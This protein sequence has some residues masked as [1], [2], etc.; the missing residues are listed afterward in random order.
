MTIT[1]NTVI[2]DL[3]SKRL[4]GSINRVDAVTASPQ[5]NGGHLSLRGVNADIDINGVSLLTT[6]RNIQDRLNILTPNKELEEEWE[7]LNH[8]GEQYR[9]LEAQLLEKSK[10]W[11]ALK[12]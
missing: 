7:Q 10:M 4:T 8:L 12:K 11:G 9:T 5:L 6:L 3:T 1:Y 2:N